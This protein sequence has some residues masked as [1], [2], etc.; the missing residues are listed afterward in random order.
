MNANP[1]K[2]NDRALDTA[3]E[4]PNPSSRLTLSLSMRL[5]IKY[6]PSK[7]QL[8]GIQSTRETCT[9]ASESGGDPHGDLEWAGKVAASKEVQFASAN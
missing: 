4:S 9:G 7:E 2:R 1:I 5:T 3:L 6:Y 8:P